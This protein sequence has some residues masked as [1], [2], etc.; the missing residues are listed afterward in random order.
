MSMLS[1]PAMTTPLLDELEIP[2]HAIGPGG[3][4]PRLALVAGLHGNDLNGIFVLS[5]LTHFLN[6][7]HA[8]ERPEQRLLERVVI[9]PAVNTTGFDRRDPRA[10]P[11]TLDIASAFADRPTIRPSV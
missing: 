3:H 11:D 2:F 10:L 7:I 6:S 9:L 4:A 1:L 8:N 5:R